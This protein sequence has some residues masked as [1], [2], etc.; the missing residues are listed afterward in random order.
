MPF[1]LFNDDLDPIVL[2]G[3][4]MQH[5]KDFEE[6]NPVALQHLGTALSGSPK[7]NINERLFKYG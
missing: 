2:G 7:K 4:L 3:D 1:N 5:L 6:F